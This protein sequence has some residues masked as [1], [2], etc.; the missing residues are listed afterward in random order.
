MNI[1]EEKPTRK[2]LIIDDDDGVRSSLGLLLKSHFQIETAENGAQGLSLLEQ[3]HPDIVL[4]DVMMPDMDGL[5][6]LRALRKESSVP[7]VMLTAAHEVRTAVQAMKLGAVDYLNKPFD[8]EDLTSVIVRVISDGPE[9]VEAVQQQVTRT[10][11]R[12]KNDRQTLL[13]GA[14][15]EIEKLRQLVQQ[16]AVKDASV[17][18]TGESGTGKEIV[19]RS[20]HLGSPRSAEPFIAINCAAIPHA[21]IESELFGHERGAF[22]SALEERTGLCE[23][24]NGGTLFLDEIG[25]LPLSTQVK[26]LRF[27][28]EQ[29]FFRVGSSK[30][31]HV[32]VR[33]VAATNRD[34]EHCVREGSFRADLFY[35]IH[36]I[37]LAVP[38]L[39]ERYNDI[40][41]LLQHFVERL[42]SRYH[43]KTI[44]FEKEAERALMQYDWPGNVRELEN[45]VESLLA[46]SVTESITVDQLPPRFLF[47]PSRD[48]P[49]AGSRGES[50][51]KIDFTDAER[52]FETEMLKKAL[53]RTEGDEAKAAEILGI[54]RRI[55]RYKMEK[56]GVSSTAE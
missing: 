27:L 54:S 19:A 34:L 32:D 51:D 4:L 48:L 29:E 26:L 41:L 1:S 50:G 45:F 9:K 47:R 53:R 38:A 12:M 10:S 30:S 56:F 2:V 13:V 6:T 15:P 23:Q 3:F 40:P 35:R 44:C 39:R 43:G 5:D 20:I 14:S 25:E 7:V 36:V 16:V 37:H 8:I 21:L 55:L 24:A 11:V 49:K 28:Q 18:I 33:V 52:I 22:T 31:R 17:L 42:S 46:L